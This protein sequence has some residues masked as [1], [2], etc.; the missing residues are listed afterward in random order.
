MQKIR[1]VYTSV[2]EIVWQVNNLE[3]DTVFAKTKEPIVFT[4][5]ISIHNLIKMASE[6]AYDGCDFDGS[7][8]ISVIPNL[9][10]MQWIYTSEDPEIAYLSCSI[11]MHCSVGLQKIKVVITSRPD[12]VWQVN[13]EELPPVTV[14]PGEPVVFVN[15]AGFHN[16]IKMATKGRYNSCDF[17]KPGNIEIEPEKG[18][19]FPIVKWVY[20][21]DVSEEAYFSCSI[22]DHCS[23]GQQKITITTKLPRRKYLKQNGQRCQDDVD[24]VLQAASV[25]TKGKCLAECDVQAPNGCFAYQFFEDDTRRECEL[26]FEAFKHTH[27]DANAQCSILKGVKPKFSKINRALCN[28]SYNN[29]TMGDEVKRPA[30]CS[31]YCRNN[32]LCRGYQFYPVQSEGRR[33]IYLIEEDPELVTDVKKFQCWVKELPQL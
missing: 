24:G 18:T 21:S 20:K 8:E 27:T 26:Y 25:N 4:N 1:V 11:G 9:P 28:A 12:I 5:G 10:V 6:D 29:S 19:T 3:F 32:W 2:P 14:V 23:A 13:G 33:C 30:R 16:L 17:D 31:R 7:E 22:L 15:G